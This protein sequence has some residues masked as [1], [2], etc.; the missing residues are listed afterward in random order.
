L[1]VLNGPQRLNDLNGWNFVKRLI[2]ELE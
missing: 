2:A 1:Y